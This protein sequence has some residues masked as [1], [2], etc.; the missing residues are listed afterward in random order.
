MTD[1]PL[2]SVVVP[3]F[4]REAFLTRACQS[5]VQQSYPR[6]EVFVVDDGSSTSLYPCFQGVAKLA[7]SSQVW[8][9]ER[10]ARSGVST[11]RNHAVSMANGEWIA[12]LDSDDEWDRR[13]VERQIAY[14]QCNTSF[15]I[16]QC[17][18]RWVRNGSFVNPRKIHAQPHGDAFE[19]SLRLCCISPS[20][21]ILE[22][23]LFEEI[24]GFDPHMPVCEDYDF[25]LRITCKEKVALQED[26][27]V[28]KYGGHADQLSRSFEAM[29]RF[30]VYSMLKLLLRAKLSSEQRELLLEVLR[31]KTEVLLAGAQK[32]GVKAVGVYSNI[33]AC[34]AASPEDD[35]SWQHSFDELCE[36]L[37]D[38]SASSYCPCQK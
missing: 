24:G 22:R 25:W 3:C 16:S 33:L 13:K 2:V 6:L 35:R 1:L 36:G 38:T 9:F 31:K 18:E 12:F 15:R 23:Q 26:L 19:S 28:T 27:L 21:V 30:R 34:C 10:I 32:R 29:D 4:E 11:A 5:V 37:I 14:H 20:S 7:P 8:H 17:Q